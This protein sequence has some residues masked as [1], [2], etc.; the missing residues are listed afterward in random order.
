MERIL[1]F[2]GRDWMDPRAGSAEHYMHEVFSRIAQQGHYVVLVAHA[3]RLFQFTDKK[4]SDVKSIDGIQIAR[5]GPRPLYGMMSAMLLD[6]IHSNRDSIPPFN[7]VI[8]CVKRRPMPLARKTKTPILPIVFDLAQGIHAAKNPPGPIIATSEFARRKLIAAGFQPRFI[9]RA[10]FGA[11]PSPSPDMNSARE[12]NALTLAVFGKA[13]RRLNAAL[14]ELAK[15]GERAQVEY[16]GSDKPRFSNADVVNHG[17]LAPVERG[18]IYRRAW[19]GFCGE[20]FEQEA[21]AMAAHSLPVVCANTEIAREYVEDGRTGFLP[22]PKDAQ[23]ISDCI[24]RLAADEAMRRRMGANARL[25]A[26]SQSWDKTAGLVLATIENI[27]NPSG[28]VPSHTDECLA[29]S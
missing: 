27:L 15:N 3:H 6:K 19:I 12:E 16:I 18:E 22:K 10:P 20:G 13:D 29:R 26:E 17:P 23:K 8:D 21:L 2:S 25:K 24:S 9:V 5:L 1:A 7:V 14:A 11:V 4:A 28:P